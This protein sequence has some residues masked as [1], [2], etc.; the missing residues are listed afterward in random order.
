M[1]GFEPCLQDKK[2]IRVIV[3]HQTKL[4]AHIIASVLA[5]EPDIHVVSTAVSPDEALAKLGRS[6]C[7]MLLVTAALPDNGALHLT[8]RIAASHPDVK[9]LVIG[10]PKSEDIILQYVMAGASGYVLQDVTTPHLLNNVRAAH[11][12]KALISPEVAALLMNQVARLAQVSGQTELDPTAVAALTSREQD[13]L[14][15]IGEAFTNQEIADHLV[16][17]VGTVKNHVHSILRKLDVGSRE[18]A[19]AYL[20]L[21]EGGPGD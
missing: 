1:A 18:E 11:D 5:E 21:L 2:M 9:V 14:R 6:E 12:E 17:T 16:I 13:V 20:E 19:A 10:V 3:V 15:L 7:N 4:I 8:E